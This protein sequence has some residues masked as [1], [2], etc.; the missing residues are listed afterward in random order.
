VE[1]FRLRFI[2]KKGRLKEVDQK[3][4]TESIIHPEN[5]GKK[6]PEKK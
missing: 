3:H 5:L 2:F 4:P 1:A 6:S